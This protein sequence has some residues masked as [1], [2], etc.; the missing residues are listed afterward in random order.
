[1]N[2]SGIGGTSWLDAIGACC[3][4]EVLELSWLD[5]LDLGPEPDHPDDEFDFTKF[6]SSIGQVGDCMD[7][8][9]SALGLAANGS[10]P[11]APQGLS[12]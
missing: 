7:Q 10:Q 9:E 6:Y 12:G 8:C 3:G 1:M 2:H 11:T 5:A 4:L